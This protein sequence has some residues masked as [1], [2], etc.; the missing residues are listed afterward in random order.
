MVCSGINPIIRDAPF[1][2]F[3]SFFNIVQ[4]AFEHLEENLRP[5]RG[6]LFRLFNTNSAVLFEHGFDPHLLFNNAK[7]N[8]EIGKEGDPFI[9]KSFILIFAYCFREDTFL[10]FLEELPESVGKAAWQQ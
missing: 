8:C 10:I 7:R 4:N 6:H 9:F 2:Q 5:L 1:Y 3:Y